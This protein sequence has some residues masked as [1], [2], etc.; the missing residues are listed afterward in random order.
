MPIYP[1]YY[2]SKFSQPA[3]TLWAQLTQFNVAN[4]QLDLYRGTAAFG[5]SPK[6]VAVA[7]RFSSGLKNL[8]TAL[9]EGGKRDGFSLSH[10]EFLTC[11]ELQENQCILLVHVP[12]LRRFTDSAKVSL[13]AV[14]WLAAQQ[15]LQAEQVGKPGMKLALGL[16]GVALYDRV[17]LGTFAPDSS[18]ATNGLSE[19]L[20]GLHP[21]HRL[22]PWFQSPQPPASSAGD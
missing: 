10:N 17:L 1:Y 11:C 7:D 15:A 4:H 6:A 5:N 19:T 13:G 12:E 16:R 18:A 8:R 9:F 3:Q 22:F 21:E 2:P 14:A 20:T